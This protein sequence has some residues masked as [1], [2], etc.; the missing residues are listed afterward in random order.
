MTIL[1]GKWWDIEVPE[2]VEE[3]EAKK[4]AWVMDPTGYFLIKVNYE[5]QKIGVAF[6]AN[7]HKITKMITGNHPEEIYYTLIREKMISVYE[8]AANIGSELQKAYIAMKNNLVYIQDD[9]LNLNN[10]RETQV[11]PET[12]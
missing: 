2:N 3:I 9:D 7:N 5:E 1:K 12:K 8:H 11:S 10:K 4:H 6:C